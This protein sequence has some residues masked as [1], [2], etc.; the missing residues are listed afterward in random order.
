MRLVVKKNPCL[1]RCLGY[2]SAQQRSRQQAASQPPDF[3]FLRMILHLATDD[4]KSS[5]RLS[6][7]FGATLKS[8][9]HLLE[10]AKDMKVEVVGISFHIGSSCTDP[11]IFTQSIADARLVFEM[12]AELGYKMHLL[13]IGGGFPGAEE[14]KGRFEEIA[15][16]VNSALDLYFPEDCGME[17]VAELGRYYVYSAFTLAVNIVAKKEVPLDQPGSD[18][19]DPCGKK[20][21]VYHVNDGV[22]GSFGSVVFSNVYPVPNLQKKPSP[23]PCLYSSSLW[24]PT[25]DGL[26]RIA[27]SMALPELHVG[28][29]LIFENMGA[30]MAPASS[31]FTGAQQ[32]QIHYAMSRVAWEAVQLLQ[33]KMLHSEEEDRE[34][35]CTPLSCGWEITDNLCVAPVF[36][37]ASIM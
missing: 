9:R 34:S 21:F 20:G 30:H 15:A 18:D 17:I 1:A 25:G 33:G 7:K 3:P 22:Y 29:W 10:T 13:D 32:A 27:D 6:M 26:D 14:T 24:G 19:E 35:T 31:T 37:P 28:D 12:G 8:C 36:T 5:A 23:D 2:G 16:V 4:S 11:Q